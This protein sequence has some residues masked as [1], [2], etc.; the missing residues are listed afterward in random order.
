MATPSA[1]RRSRVLRTV[2]VGVALGGFLVPPASAQPAIGVP[3]CRVV[4]ESIPRD[5]SVDVWRPLQRFLDNVPDGSCIEFPQG[6]EYRVERTLRVRNKDRLTLLGSGS[7]IFATSVRRDQRP[8]R[9]KKG[10]QRLVIENSSNIRVQ[11]LWIDG[12]AK[13]CRYDRLTEGQA[14]VLV[15]GSTNVLLLGLKITQVAGD[16]LQIAGTYPETSEAVPARNVTFS[17]GRIKCTGRQG[18]TMTLADGVLIEE[19][20]LKA[21]ARTA[22]DLEPGTADDT[23]SNVRIVHNRIGRF[24]HAFIGGAGAGT[25]RD[26]YVGFNVLT[27]RSMWSKIGTAD[28]VTRENITFEGNISEVLF[29]RSGQALINIAN[30]DNFR[31]EGNT[32]HFPP[33]GSD[34]GQE[35]YYAVWGDATTCPVYAGANVLTGAVGVFDPA[36]SVNPI[37]WIDEGGNQ[38]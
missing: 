3:L 16:G 25:V 22:F 38:Y 33:S 15:K 34:K 9:K 1:P 20:S 32:Q 17:A 27:R 30:G 7:K 26:V 10:R 24:K 5:G 28:L 21:V 2:L 23:V 35:L 4:P 12:A 11:D 37:C 29:D 8:G 13:S 31:F 36:A 19:S 6:A 18:I 14:G